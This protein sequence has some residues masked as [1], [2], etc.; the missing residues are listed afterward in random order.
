ML[1]SYVCDCCISQKQYI[2]YNLFLYLQTKN[3]N[4][5][6]RTVDFEYIYFQESYMQNETTKIMIENN[7]LK[8]YLFPTIQFFNNSKDEK[9]FTKYYY[10]YSIWL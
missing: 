9:N 7:V 6:F 4:F 5:K 8:Y 1:K 2:L 10:N 3:Y